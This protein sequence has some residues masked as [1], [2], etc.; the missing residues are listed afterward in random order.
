[1]SSNDL[2]ILERV[3]MR[4][5][6]QPD[7]T[8]MQGM[9]AKIWGAGTASVSELFYSTDWTRA[10]ASEFRVHQQIYGSCRGGFLVDSSLKVAMPSFKKLF[11]LYNLHELL[12]RVEVKHAMALDPELSFFMD[13][14]N[15]CYYAHKH[16]RLFVY[17]TTFDE[18]YERGPI[19]SALEE[20]IAEWEAAAPSESSLQR[21]GAVIIDPDKPIA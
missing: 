15:V 19:E 2:G 8:Y 16:G 10:P 11:G 6:G 18:L 3:L 17:D 20:I 4:R 7:E 14:S 13:A 9:R 5:Y 1:M 12:E 21:T